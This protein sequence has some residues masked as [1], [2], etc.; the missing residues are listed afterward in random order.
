MI[1][2]ELDQ[3]LDRRKQNLLDID[4]IQFPSKVVEDKNNWPKL[5]NKLSDVLSKK[6]GQIKVL[7]EVKKKSPSLG[8]LTD[9]DAYSLCES[10]ISDGAHAI[11]VLVDNVNFGGYP[12]DLK[13]CAEGFPD[14]PMLYK[15]FVMETYQVYLARTLGAS[16]ILLMTQVLDDEELN[17]LFELSVLIGLEPFI[18]VH[19]EEQLQRALA[20][21]PKVIG[22][23]A[24]DFSKKGLPVDLENAGKLLENYFKHNQWPEHTFLIAQSGI[25]SE[26][27][28]ET[29]VK[30]C[31]E[32]FPHAVQIG[33]S[34]SK[35]RNL[36]QWLF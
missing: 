12:M 23:N 32:G 16:N 26:S 11:S 3:I 27:T 10:F 20:L 24:R 14:T 25:D 4:Q 7:A 15:D 5:N 31:P 30:G 22:I 9:I 33:S 17:E 28:Y 36:P 19:D 2:S 34:V 21:S 18:E 1:K 8:A 13:V 6:K 29:V 35:S